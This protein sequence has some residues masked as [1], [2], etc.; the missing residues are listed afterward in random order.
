[1]NLNPK[2]YFSSNPTAHVTPPPCFYTWVL[3][4]QIS[5]SSGETLGAD[6]DLSSTAGDGPGGRV[7]PHL[8][9]SRGTL[10]DS[11]I[12]TNPATSTVFVS[13]KL[14]INAICGSHAVLTLDSS[15]LKT[16]QFNNKPSIFQL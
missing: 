8:N 16:I 13:R 7:A 1:M 3:T 4:F 2:S 6:S 12:E 14:K 11:E 10:S 15:Q 9:Q 5:N